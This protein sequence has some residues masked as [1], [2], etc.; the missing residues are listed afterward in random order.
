MV[1]VFLAESRISA[2]KPAVQ[3]S[4]ETMQ[5]LSAYDWPGNVR[6]LKH[7]IE[8]AVIHAQ[9]AVLQPSHLTPEI[10]GPPTMAP[11]VPK[12]SLGDERTRIL[13]ALNI[14][15]E[16][17]AHAAKILGISR[18]TLYRRIRELGL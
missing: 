17:R 3:V 4:V 16:N 8:Y 14:A 10:S 2:G 6:E 7:A 11:E 18:S 12:L 15:K 5:R 13:A 9:S 1:S